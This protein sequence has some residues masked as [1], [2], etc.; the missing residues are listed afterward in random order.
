M[1]CVALSFL[2]SGM[3]SGILALSQIRIRQLRRAGNPR[4]ELLDNYLKQPENFL[5]TILI[6]NTVSNFTVLAITAFSIN[7][8]LPSQRLLS[9]ALF[10]IAFFIFYCICEL[11]SKMLFRM[12]PNRLCLFF[13]VPFRFLHIVLS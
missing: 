7:H 13:V 9:V 10:L 2:L 6:G 12:F 5:W 4:A 3:E 1:A 11:L 8:F